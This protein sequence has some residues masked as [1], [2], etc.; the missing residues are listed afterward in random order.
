[1]TSRLRNLGVR[2]DPLT[3][4]VLVDQVRIGRKKHRE[5]VTELLRDSD[6]LAALSEQQRGKRMA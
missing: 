6:R 5:R 4:I 2:V 1:L 3:V